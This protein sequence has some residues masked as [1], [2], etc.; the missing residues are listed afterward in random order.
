MT[1]KETL[2]TLLLAIVIGVTVFVAVTPAC[3]LILGVNSCERMM[4]EILVMRQPHS[5]ASYC[6][7][8][9]E[10]FR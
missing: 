2:K 4:C 7:H 1:R 3:I 10:L 6:A 5:D 8:W 9:F